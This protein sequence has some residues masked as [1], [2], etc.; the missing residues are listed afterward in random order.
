VSHE[1]Q[2]DTAYLF[3]VNGGGKEAESEELC[4]FYPQ[5]GFY[6]F[7]ACKLEKLPQK[8]N[9]PLTLKICFRNCSG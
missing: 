3:V 4:F 6:E 5:E 7:S 1:A 2:A 8:I 9:Q